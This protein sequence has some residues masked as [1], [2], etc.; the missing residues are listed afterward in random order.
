MFL[1][2]K[3]HTIHIGETGDS[4]QKKFLF[5]INS[6]IV[7]LGIFFLRK[8]GIVFIILA[9]IPLLWEKNHNVGQLLTGIK[10]LGSHQSLTF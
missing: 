7:T 1:Q 9:V 8:D 3:S 10:L 2:F 5:R 6:V 4:L